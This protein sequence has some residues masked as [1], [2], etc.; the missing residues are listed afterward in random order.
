MRLNLPTIRYPIDFM[1]WNANIRVKVDALFHGIATVIN[2][3]TCEA[4]VHHYHTY[5]FHNSPTIK[6]LNIFNTLW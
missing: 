1:A 2:F 4:T 6:M 3:P 5:N